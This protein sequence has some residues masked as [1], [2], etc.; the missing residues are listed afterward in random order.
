MEEKYTTRQAMAYEVGLDVK[1][2]MRKIEELNIFLKARERISPAQQHEIR[3]LILGKDYLNK[4]H[5]NGS[6]K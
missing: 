1:A 4:R 6:A 2:F 3:V 5:G